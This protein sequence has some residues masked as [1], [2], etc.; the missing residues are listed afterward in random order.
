MSGDISAT[1]QCFIAFLNAGK[2]LQKIQGAG[3]YLWQTSSCL[4][5]WW[6]TVVQ[7]VKAVFYDEAKITAMVARENQ[8]KS[9]AYECHQP[10]RISF[11]NYFMNY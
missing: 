1:R 4:V 2:K 6:N 3:E 11:V 8:L 7:T 9:Y 10:L 5:L